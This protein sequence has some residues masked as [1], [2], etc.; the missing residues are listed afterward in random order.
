MNKFSKVSFEQYL[1]D[2]D[3]SL[4]GVDVNKTYDEII[5][6]KRSTKGSAGYDFFAPF[7]FIIHPNET[8]KVPTGIKCQIDSRWF[9]GIFI[10][11]SLG[12]KYQINIVNQT[13][14]ID[15]DYFNNENNEGHIMIKLVNRGSGIVAIKKGCGIAQGIFLPYGLTVDDYSKNERTGGIGSTDRKV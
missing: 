7:D 2:F 4:E 8:F 15:E 12:F 3:I 6:P 1:R 13:G 10:R 14:I 9:L 11:S 5:L